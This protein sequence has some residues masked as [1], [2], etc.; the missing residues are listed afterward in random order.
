MLMRENWEIQWKCFGEIPIEK[1]L[2]HNKQYFWSDN[3]KKSST[4]YETKNPLKLHHKRYTYQIGSKHHFW[5][6]LSIDQTSIF[7]WK[8][9]QWLKLVGWS[10]N[11]AYAPWIMFNKFRWN[12]WIIF[13]FFFF[14]DCSNFHNTLDADYLRIKMKIVL[15]VVFFSLSLLCIGWHF[16]TRLTYLSIYLYLYSRKVINL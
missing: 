8:I 5:L 2:N 3:I 7:L 4:Y 16:V 14:L 11:F 9:L 1:S 6:N 15:V 13:V 12:S 10:V